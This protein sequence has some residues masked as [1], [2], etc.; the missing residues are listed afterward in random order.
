MVKYLTEVVCHYNN[1]VLPLQYTYVYKTIPTYFEHFFLFKRNSSGS[2]NI[3][4][5]YISYHFVV[6]FHND[7]CGHSISGKKKLS[8][9]INILAVGC[10]RLHINISRIGNCRI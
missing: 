5:V 10:K 1:I 8:A 6:W 3:Q 7:C 2:I 4:I 9:C